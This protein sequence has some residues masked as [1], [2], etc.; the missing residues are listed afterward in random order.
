M[1][2]DFRFI[3]LG[4]LLFTTQDEQ[5]NFMDGSYFCFISLSTIGFGDIVPKTNSNKETGTDL[6]WNFILCSVYLMLGMALIAMC[7]N[8]MQQDV[9]QK[10]RTCTDIIRRLARCRRW[11]F[12]PWCLRG[13]LMKKARQN[14]LNNVLIWVSLYYIVPFSVRWTS[15][16]RQQKCWH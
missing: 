11:V 10:I 9:V 1:K 4:A 8:L 6:Q 12:H 7:F 15:I 2:Y 5:L 13:K 14:S 3:S 16:G